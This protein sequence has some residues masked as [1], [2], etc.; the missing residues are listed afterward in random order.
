MSAGVSPEGSASYPQSRIELPRDARNSFRAEDEHTDVLGPSPGLL[1]YCFDRN[2][3]SYFPIAPT[4]EAGID[5]RR[6]CHAGHAGPAYSEGP[7]AGTHAWLGNHQP[8]S[9][10]V[11][12]HLPDRA[13]VLVSRPPSIRE[14]GSFVELLAGHREQSHSEVLRPDVGRKA[15]AG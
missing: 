8:H 7:F 10:D 13:R 15:G 14:S 5:P 3:L 6:G 11:P 4:G 9:T 2:E 1:P 12:G